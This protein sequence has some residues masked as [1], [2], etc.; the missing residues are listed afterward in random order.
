MVRFIDLAVGSRVLGLGQAM[1]DGVAGAPY[2]KGGSPELLAALKHTFDVGDRPIL[3]GGIGEVGPI[4]GQHGVDLVGDRFDEVQQEVSDDPLCRLLVQ[5]GAGKLRGPIDGDEEVEPAPRGAYL[6]DV[7][8][9]VADRVGPEPLRPCSP[10]RRE[11][12]DA[13]PLR[14]AVQGRPRQMRYCNDDGVVL[15]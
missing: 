14:A 15:E 7:D 10:R 9:E 6:G 13:M 11:S 5:L 4:V 1:I 12:R 3:A 2:V 8:M